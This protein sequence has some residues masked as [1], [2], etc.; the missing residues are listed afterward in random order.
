M[1]RRG[2]VPQK[3]PA[4]CR[5]VALDQ[6]WLPV[7]VS[8]GPPRADS[9]QVLPYRLRQGVVGTQD[10]FAVGQGLLVERQRVFEAARRVIGGGEVAACGQ[11]VGVVAALGAFPAGQGLVGEREC[12]LD[13]PRRVVG[14]GEVASW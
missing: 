6:S 5:A 7:L 2:P 8:R 9:R 3:R 1:A 14:I 11:C 10:A 4:T 12:V 13:P